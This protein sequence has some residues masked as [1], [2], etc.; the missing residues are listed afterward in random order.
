[1]LSAWCAAAAVERGVRA[2][3]LRIFSPSSAFTE[4]M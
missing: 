3:R 2:N 1:M 4:A